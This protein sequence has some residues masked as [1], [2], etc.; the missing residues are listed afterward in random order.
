[1]VLRRL[2]WSCSS[3]IGHKGHVLIAPFH[4]DLLLARIWGY[5]LALSTVLTRFP[6]NSTTLSNEALTRLLRGMFLER[7]PQKELLPAWDLGQVFQ[8]L[9]LA[10]FKPLNILIIGGMCYRQREDLTMPLLEQLDNVHVPWWQIT[11]NFQAFTCIRM[12]KTK[13]M[14]QILSINWSSFKAGS[15]KPWK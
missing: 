10:P 6:R 7:L 3:G 13:Q 14:L 12:N 9:K 4:Q 2:C 5:H 8:S 11:T 1:M 15:E